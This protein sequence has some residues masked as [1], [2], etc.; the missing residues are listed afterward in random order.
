MKIARLYLE[1]EDPVQA[2]AFI[3]RASHLQVLICYILS[4]VFPRNLQF[5]YVEFQSRR[6]RMMKNSKY[7]TKYVMLVYSTIEENSSKPLNVIMNYPIVRLST[8]EK[9]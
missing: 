6:T 1:D 7:T 3:N 4:C 5:K 9:E 8:K 2:E